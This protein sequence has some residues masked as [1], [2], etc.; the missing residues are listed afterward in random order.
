MYKEKRRIRTSPLHHQTER[1]LMT[2]PP[3]TANPTNAALRLIFG[4]ISWELQ[5]DHTASPHCGRRQTIRVVEEIRSDKVYG[6]KFYK[7]NYAP[8]KYPTREVVI[9]VAGPTSKPK[10]F[11][12]LEQEYT[13]YSTFSRFQGTVFPECLGIFRSYNSDGYATIVCLV[14][15]KCIPS[16]T[17]DKDEF[18][19][20]I[21][22]KI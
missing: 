19:Y 12:R 16:A 22:L 2:L 4:D 11:E 14:L 10:D 5:G 18:K 3:S 8:G 21:F 6:G 1:P 17:Y 15:E 13:L 9:K 20:V 7:G